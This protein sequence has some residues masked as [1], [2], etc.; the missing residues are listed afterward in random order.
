MALLVPSPFP[1]S[2][3]IRSM[4]SKQLMFHQKIE[5]TYIVLFYGTRSPLCQAS[6]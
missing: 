6:L 4:D 1:L 3:N 5:N 2:I